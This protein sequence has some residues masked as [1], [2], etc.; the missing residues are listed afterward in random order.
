[1]Y[2]VRS[3]MI[4]SGVP[5]GTHGAALGIGITGPH[6][7]TFITAGHV[8]GIGVIATLGIVTITAVHSVPD[9]SFVRA[10]TPCTAV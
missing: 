10:I 6:G 7:G 1:M 4:G 8:T 2:I 3:S 9:M 5:L